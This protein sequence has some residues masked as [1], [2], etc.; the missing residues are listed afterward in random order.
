MQV[1][2]CCVLIILLSSLALCQTSRYQLQAG[3]V[4]GPVVMT[5]GS[6]LIDVDGD[7][8]L[9]VVFANGFVLQITGS[10]ILP[11]IL[12]NKISLGQGLVDE[13]AA[14]LPALAIRGTQVVA[15]DCDA[16]GDQDLIFTCNGPSQ[17]RLYINNGAGVFSDQSVARLGTLSISATCAAYG[18]IDRDGDLDLFLNDE[19]TNGQLKLF[20][21]NGLGFFTNAT[22]SRLPVAPK[23]NQQDINVVD[24]DNDWDL[25]VI[26]CGKSSGQQIFLNDGTGVFTVTTALLPAGGTLTYETDVADLDNDGDMDL[27]MLSTGAGLSDSV[28]RNNVIPNGTL[29]F[30]ASSTFFTGGNGDDD[31]EFVY[32]DAD[33]NGLLDIVIGSL[34]ASS[35]KLYINNGSFSFARA[36]GTAGFTSVT[37]STLDVAV[38]DLNGDGTLDMITGQGESGSFLNR[39]YYGQTADTLGPR[40]VRIEGIPDSNNAAG[41]WRARLVLQD[42]GVDDSETTVR[43][44]VANWSIQHRGGTTN[45]ATSA[46]TLGGLMWEVSLVAQPSILMMGSEVT[47]SITATDHA[48]NITVSPSSTFRI[49]GFETY[50]QGLLGINTASLLGSGSTTLGQTATVTWTVAPPNVGGLLAIA[51]DRAATPVL[52]GTVL[53][54][55]SIPP[56]LLPITS[57]GA[58]SGFVS[59]LIPNTPALALARFDFQAV[60]DP[61]LAFTN[62]LEAVI[63]P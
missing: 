19:A 23:S 2:R 7:T 40:F 45:L 6:I 18:D 29:S 37:D 30:T 33:N 63:C 58:G 15:F 27:C 59:F 12:I 39:T 13:T 32:V 4:T 8:D 26:N 52:G 21:N 35:E 10:S 56:L 9:D 16:D 17:Q 57:D 36:T 34:Q 61:P 14:R 5:E 50:G 31:N 49:C 38:G 48:G 54:D 51:A 24:I 47:W 3:L 44:I 22:A 1:L 41:P 20:L 60:F 11:T 53:I 55:L 62:G 28:I 46:R 25:D 43:S 42:S